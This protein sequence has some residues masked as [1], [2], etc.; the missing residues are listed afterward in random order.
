MPSKSSNRRRLLAFLAPVIDTAA[1]L[2]AAIWSSSQWGIDPMDGG[3]LEDWPTLR[4]RIPGLVKGHEAAHTAQ[5]Q[6]DRFLVGSPPPS[7]TLLGRMREQAAEICKPEAAALPAA[8]HP[9]S[10]IARLCEPPA[11]P[12]RHPGQT[13][14]HDRPTPSMVTFRVLSPTPGEELATLFIGGH[15]SS[16]LPPVTVYRDGTVDTRRTTLYLPDRTGEPTSELIPQS[17]RSALQSRAV[18]A[19]EARQAALA[20]HDYLVEAFAADVLGLARS[21]RWREAVST[22]L[23]GDW[24]EPLFS[25]QRLDDAA[26]T[27]LRVE[28][29]TTH[30]H[31]V[32][33][34]RRR[35][36]HGRVLLL[37]TPLGDGLS[38]HDLASGI[39]D[40][41]APLLEH[42]PEDAR[43]AA[44][45]RALQPAER[46]AAL[47]WAD[48]NVRSWTEAA[49]QA[50]ADDPIA[51]GERV[52]RKCRRLAAELA[53]RRSLTVHAGG[54]SA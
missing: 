26:V 9:A 8:G 19:L 36:R 44:L 40:T 22:A 35:T 4:L 30:R 33:L 17:D 11:L 38:L 1:E 7:E 41:K 32:P 46:A 3:K 51:F 16:P 42:D 37:D 39:T 18:Q 27:R 29:R 45:I 31:L 48:P 23:L 50:G 49:Q 28:A 52:R 25:G 12:I 5:P 15:G 6:S 14:G 10:G 43:L 53:R 20:G 13:M 21:A 54:E 47:A 24:A 2:L 34:W